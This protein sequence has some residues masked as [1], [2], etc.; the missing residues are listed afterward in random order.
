MSKT[1]FDSQQAHASNTQPGL[2][3][4]T[5]NTQ[6]PNLASTKLNLWQMHTSKPQ[7]G[8]NRCTNTHQRLNLDRSKCSKKLI[9]ISNWPATVQLNLACSKRTWELINVSNRLA[10]VT[11]WLAANAHGNSSTSQTGWQ[12]FNS[13]CS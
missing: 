9:N 8:L 2:Q 3:H 4:C 6:R 12:Q 5:N 13:A 7:T 1:R 11:T 10:T